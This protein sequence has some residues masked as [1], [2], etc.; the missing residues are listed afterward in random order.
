[1]MSK[2]PIA[3]ASETS[4][5]LHH[6]P[7]HVEQADRLIAIERALG[8]RGL[9]GEL[10]RLPH[11][12]AERSLLET[13]HAPQMLTKIERLSAQ[14]NGAIDPDTYVCAG[15]WE[16]ACA[17]AGAVIAATDA[18]VR[19]ACRAAFGLVRPPGHHATPTQAMGFCLINNIAVAAR[20]AIDHLGLKRVAIVDYDVHHGNGTQDIFYADPQ[21]LF[22]S[23]H[24]APFYPGTGDSSELGSGAGY[25]T[26]LNIPL[27]YHCPDEAYLTVID[28]VLEPALQRFQPELLF[29]SAGFDAHWR[30]PLSPMRLSIHGYHAITARL[31]AISEKLCDGRMVLALEGGYDH[32]VLS[33][34]VVVV[35]QCLLGQPIAADPIGVPIGRSPDLRGL[36]G[37]LKRSHPLLRPLEEL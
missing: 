18:V 14:G 3:I 9:L 37:E 5:V 10:W 7:T 22:C 19:G 23:I 30:D 4:H 21:V 12:P 20:Y 13:V 31:Q 33:E 28:E 11:H 8:E 36:I 1:M 35:L 17:G 26:T 2:L 24:A 15:S 27:P 16:V 6:R 34:S 29:V 25:G 32:E